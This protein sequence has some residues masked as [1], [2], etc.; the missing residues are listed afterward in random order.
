MDIPIPIEWEWR[1][2]PKILIRIHQ[3]PP[4]SPSPMPSQIFLPH[5]PQPDHLHLFGHWAGRHCAPVPITVAMRVESTTCCILASHRQ[6]NKNVSYCPTKM[7]VAH[8]S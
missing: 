2:L 8:T 1:I 5:Y 6:H 7:R 3:S 4:M